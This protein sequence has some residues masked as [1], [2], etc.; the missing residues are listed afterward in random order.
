MTCR[1]DV[2]EQALERAGRL[3]EG[4]RADGR[5]APALALDE[6]LVGETAHGVAH[7]LT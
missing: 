7:R 5:A 4:A 2:L 6:A 3:L 1:L